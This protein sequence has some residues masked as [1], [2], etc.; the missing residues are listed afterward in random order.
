MV[1]SENLEN[2]ESF[3]IGTP[4]TGGALKLKT[5][6]LLSPEFEQRINKVVE[7]WQKLQILNDQFKTQRK[8]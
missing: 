7:L 1:L 3:T 2:Y 5:N 4:A 6:D 8:G